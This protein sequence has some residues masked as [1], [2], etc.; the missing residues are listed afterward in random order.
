MARAGNRAYEATEPAADNRAYAVWLTF[1][2]AGGGPLG[3]EAAGQ[4]AEPDP[5]QPGAGRPVR[6]PGLG[7]YRGEDHDLGPGKRVP[8]GRSVSRGQL[9]PVPVRRR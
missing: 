5:A 2:V 1:A 8:A 6:R 3:A 4:L 7:P 9:A